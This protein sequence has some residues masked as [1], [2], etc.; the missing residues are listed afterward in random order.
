MTIH[1]RRVHKRTKNKEFPSGTSD[2]GQHDPKKTSI[3]KVSHWDLSSC[4]EAVEV[5]HSNPP[6]PHVPVSQLPSNITNIYLHGNSA[7][8]QPLSH[9]SVSAFIHPFPVFI[10]PSRPLFPICWFSCRQ[11]AHC[12][13]LRVKK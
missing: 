13:F 6:P 4:P 11:I 3:C 7:R 8:K 5:K 10:G 1:E 12:L 9:S 2:R